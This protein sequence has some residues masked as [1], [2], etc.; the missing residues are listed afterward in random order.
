M[1]KKD[2]PK[3]PPKPREP[4]IPLKEQPKKKSLEALAAKIV[5]EAKKKSKEAPPEEPPKK[6]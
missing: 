2:E 3:T 1:T 4:N 6:K 5:D